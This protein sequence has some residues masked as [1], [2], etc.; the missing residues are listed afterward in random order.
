MSPAEHVVD[1]AAM[2]LLV[3]AVAPALLVVVLQVHPRAD[4]WSPPAVLALPAFVLLHAG[5]TIGGP[6]LGPGPAAAA[7]IALLVGAVA[8]WAPVLGVHRRLPDAGRMFYLYLAMPMLDLAGVWLVAA[9]DPSGG[10]AMIVGML[11]MA[12]IT[13]VLTWQWISG[14][15]RRTALEEARERQEATG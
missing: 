3:G 1:M 6:Y 9:G 15:E 2:G 13:V 4:R 14:E 10:L 8:F 12:V 11:P 5:A 7:H